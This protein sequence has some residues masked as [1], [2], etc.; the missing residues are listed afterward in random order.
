VREYLLGHETN[1][2]NAAKSHLIILSIFTIFVTHKGFQMKVTLNIPESVQSKAF[3]F[4]LYVASKMYEDGLFSAGQASEMAGVSK[5]T[6]IELMG[7]YG[8][9]VFSSSVDDLL[10]DINNA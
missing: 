8:V 3:D 4:S 10:S 1:T 9:S 6:F 2:F 7:K 5:R